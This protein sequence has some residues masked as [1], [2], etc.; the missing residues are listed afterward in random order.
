MLHAQQVWDAEFITFAKP[1]GADPFSAENQ[2]RISPS[3]WITRDN[4]RGI[5]NIRI[6]PE[7]TRQE[8]PDDT[9][10]AFSGLNGN[11]STNFGAANYQQLTFNNW[12]D[13]LGGRT[14]VLQ[15][16]L[17]RPAVLHLLVEDVYIDIEFSAWGDS[18]DGRFTYTRASAPTSITETA[19]DIPLP[20]WF[21]L[22][23]GAGLLMAGVKRRLSQP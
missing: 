10:W 14:E 15:N 11:P 8:S 4:T 16:I 13:A 20:L 17:S 21:Y 9:R 5:F 19:E 22:V 23:T 7:Y 18:G 6:E 3:V 2:D 1:P 12:E